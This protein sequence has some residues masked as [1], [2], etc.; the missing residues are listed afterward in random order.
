MRLNWGGRGLRVCVPVLALWLLTAAG[1]RA[2][3]H[4]PNIDPESQ[5][6]ILVQRIQQEPTPPRKLAL[7]EKFVAE[8]PKSNSAAWVYEQLLPIYKE[9]NEQ[10]KV[11]ATADALLAVDPNDLDAAHDALKA[12]ETKADPDLTQKYAAL[13][14]DVASKAAQ[15]AKPA[16][17]DEAAAWTKQVQFANEVL[18]YTEYTLAA[19]AK[20][21]TDEQKRAALVQALQQRNPQSQY[22]AITKKPTVIDLASLDPQ[23]AVALAEQGLVT[24]PDNEDFLMTVADYY[25]NR[26]KELP[27]VLSYALRV[28]DLLQ[29]KAKPDKISDEEWNKKKSKYS[30]WSNWLA[31]VVY[32]KQARYGLSDRYL[33]A[34]LPFIKGDSRLLS[35]AYFYLGYDN[36]ALARETS[37][38]GLA[39]EAVK[40]SKLC[41]AIEGPFQ[42]L[43]RKNLETLRNEYNLE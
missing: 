16:D 39:I 18:A 15:S 22:L 17:P 1:V 3:R 29:R 14:W 30:G 33:R 11:L 10:D 34:A 6:G 41:A 32:A 9:A 8:Y 7:L 42:P 2:D 27:K 23:K 26:E 12:V 24:D 37:D 31:G 38:K 28:L 43:A 21:Q 5:D 19:L 20:A 35:A 13:A 36:Y 25:M 40:F 4:K